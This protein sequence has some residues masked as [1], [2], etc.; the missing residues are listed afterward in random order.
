MAERYH[1]LMQP[2]SSGKFCVDAVDDGTGVI[3]CSCWKTPYNDPQLTA[4]P[5]LSRKLS[6]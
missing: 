6:S 5:L 4:L 1:G 3:V 2:M